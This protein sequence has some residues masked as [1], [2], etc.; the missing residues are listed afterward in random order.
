MYIYIK[1]L[2]YKHDTHHIKRDTH[3]SLIGCPA[4]AGACYAR[5]T[6]LNMEARWRV[7][8]VPPLSVDGRK[9]AV[10]EVF[11]PVS[12]TCRFGSSETRRSRDC[13]TVTPNFVRFLARP[14][15]RLPQPRRNSSHTGSLSECH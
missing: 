6:L 13:R 5:T 12:S 10:A 11:D 7:Y 9:A 3:Y 8:G 14:D 1:I 2:L 4:L 15:Q